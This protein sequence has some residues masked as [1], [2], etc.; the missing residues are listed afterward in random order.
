MGSEDEQKTLFPHGSICRCEFMWLL[1]QREEERC[2]QTRKRKE[3]ERQ[4]VIEKEEERTNH[5]CS[6]KCRR[7]HTEMIQEMT[8]RIIRLKKIFK[9]VHRRFKC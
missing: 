7:E 8:L 6:G 3:N 9:K 5:K 4:Y 1:C 2:D